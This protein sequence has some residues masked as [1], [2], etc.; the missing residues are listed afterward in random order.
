MSAHRFLYIRGD[1]Q[2][3]YVISTSLIVSGIASFIQVS[4]F[5]I[6]YTNVVV[7][8]GLISVMGT[9][10]TFLPVA[11]DALAQVSDDVMGH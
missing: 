9:S 5:K 3:Q 11:I 10:F 8:T 7:G 2:I 4:R 1:E 6:P